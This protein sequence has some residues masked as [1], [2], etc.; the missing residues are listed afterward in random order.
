[1]CNSEKEREFRPTNNATDA[2][3]ITYYFYVTEIKTITI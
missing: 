1:M 2:V 3:E